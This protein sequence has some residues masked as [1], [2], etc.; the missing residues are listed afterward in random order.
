[1]LIGVGFVD[2]DGYVLA[3]HLGLDRKG[4][5]VSHATPVARPATGN[6]RPRARRGTFL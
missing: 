5:K 3:Q 4:K 1:V 2:E 6:T